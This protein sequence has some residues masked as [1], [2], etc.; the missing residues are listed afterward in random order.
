MI[1]KP[2]PLKNGDKV[3][4]I[5]PSSA[6]DLKTVNDGEARVKAMGIEPVMFPSCYTRYGHLS[7][8]D[9]ERAR[10]INNA[11]NDESIKG[12]ICLRGGYGTPRILNMIDYGVV[13]ANP[14]I[15]IG[16]SDITALHVAFNQI[17][18]MV[19]YHGPMAVS[20]FSK[21]KNNVHDFEKYTY[22]SLRKNIFTNEAVGLFKN[23][24]NENLETVNEG[25]A[26]GE[27]IGGNLTLLC[28][29]LGSPYEID[30]KGKILF[31]EEVGEPVYKIDR[32]LTSLSLSNKFKDCAGIILGTFTDCIREKKAYEEGY[33]L[34]LEEVI[35]NTIVPFNK[36]IISNFRAG[37]NFPQ[38]TIPLGT[39]IKM[40]A[41][42]K[43]IIFTESGNQ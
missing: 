31:I 7:A 14:K 12:I 34:P 24:E 23:P 6:T 1:I 32:M 4:V 15:F 43:E 18:R 26:E 25:K 17:S 42:K 36:P 27:I 5:A 33:D 21:F 20:S 41:F 28:S 11:F 30:T 39:H 3:A 37:H 40:D 19:T 13:R 29:A 8:T 10:D 9:E 16:Y 35:K 2:K 22:E 38:P